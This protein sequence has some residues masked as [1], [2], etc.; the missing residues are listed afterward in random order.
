MNQPY[1]KQFT[2][3]EKGETVVSNP[4]PSE[5]LFAEYPNRRMRR[6]MMR[7]NRGLNC[8][9]G[10]NRYQQRMKPVYDYKLNDKGERVPFIT[11]S[12]PDG[13]RTICHRI[14]IR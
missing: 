14:E 4:I 7:R 12:I 3:N 5:G 8:R 6:N 13:A 10:R 1:V 11:H 2:T 9:K